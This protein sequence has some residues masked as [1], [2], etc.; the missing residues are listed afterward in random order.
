MLSGLEIRSAKKAFCP[1][2]VKLSVERRGSMVKI[3][4]VKRH[5]V[6]FM[7]RT[8]G[9]GRATDRPLRILPPENRPASEVSR[10]V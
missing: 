2:N 3:K 1:Q 7:P 6:P 5:N 10:L 9:G 8:Q 4:P